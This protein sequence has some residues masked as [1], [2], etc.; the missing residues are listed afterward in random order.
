MQKKTDLILHPKRM[1]ILT[2][3]GQRPMSGQALVRELPDISQASLYRHLSTL[4]KGGIVEMINEDGAKHYRIVAGQGRL[5]PD[6]LADL[7]GADLVGAFT[8]FCSNL[9]AHFADLAEGKSAMEVSAMGASFNQT[10]IEMTESELIE[11]TEAMQT[12]IARRN[13]AKE[14]QVKRT[15]TLASV[16]LPQRGQQNAET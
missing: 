7:S 14:G 4:I 13:P 11:L 9:I 3:L 15:Y 16:L 1:Q 10:T 2:T 6:D 8:S 5:R 12:I